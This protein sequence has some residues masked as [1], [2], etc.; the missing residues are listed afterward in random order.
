MKVAPLNRWLNRAKTATPHNYE[1]SAMPCSE[2]EVERRPSAALQKPCCTKPRSASQAME[3]WPSCRRGGSEVAA[4]RRGDRNFT[5][6][7]RAVVH[8]VSHHDP[9]VQ[10][11]IS[12]P[13]ACDTVADIDSGPVDDDR[14]LGRDVRGHELSNFRTWYGRDSGPSKDS[15]ILIRPPQH[16]QGGGSISGAPS[17]S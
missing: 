5:G 17:S 13:K 11:D 3:I 12:V 4:L 6:V 7:H 10:D 14:L 2:S 8:D 16:G 15:T 1:V 9:P